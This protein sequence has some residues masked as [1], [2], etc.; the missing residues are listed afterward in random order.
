M[1]KYVLYA[2]TLLACFG[3]FTGIYFYGRHTANE[4]HRLKSELQKKEVEIL[5][6][7]EIV[8]EKEVV[9]QYK[10]RIKT[11]TEFQTNIVEVVNE[12]LREDSSKC[13][14]GNGF[15]WLH[16]SAAS[17][18]TIPRSTERIDDDHQQTKAIE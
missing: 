11:I 12:V 8:V 14:F 10:D 15:I 18:E 13:S 4:E 9:T 17:G 6:Q 2:A 16:N 7:K 3:A 5:M 1:S